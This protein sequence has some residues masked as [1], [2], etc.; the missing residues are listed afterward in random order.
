VFSSGV[1]IALDPALEGARA[2]DRALARGR[3][4][5][6]GVRPL[7]SAQRQRYAAFRRFVL[8]F[9]TPAFR[10]LFFSADPP[11]TCSA[12]SSR[13]SPATGGPRSRRAP[14]WRCSSSGAAAAALRLRAS[15]VQRV[16][17]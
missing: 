14:G 15:H 11:R 10:D 12:P 16:I 2:V 5:R 6:A 9:Y 17:A 7:R 8:G 1:A 13:C 4:E 3:V